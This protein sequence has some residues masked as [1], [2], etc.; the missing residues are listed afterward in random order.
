MDVDEIQGL[1]CGPYYPGVLGSDVA[2]DP[3]CGLIEIG[4]GH[5]FVHRSEVVQGGGV[6][7]GGSEEQ[8]THHVLWDQ[9]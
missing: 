5:H 2:G 1:L 6:D 4:A 7:G 3:Q 8:P 9:S